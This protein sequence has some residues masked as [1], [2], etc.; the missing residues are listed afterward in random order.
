[1]E[2]DQN[3][4][5]ECESDISVLEYMITKMRPP[6]QDQELKEPHTIT[7]KSHNRRVRNIEAVAV[8]FSVQMYHN[9]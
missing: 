4:I 6:P 8:L 1:M 3:D 2:H 7:S 5:H 9:Y